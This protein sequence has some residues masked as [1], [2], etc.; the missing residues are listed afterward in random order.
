MPADFGGDRIREISGVDLKPVPARPRGQGSLGL[1]SE[2]PLTDRFQKKTELSVSRT[3]VEGQ[4]ARIQVP[5]EKVAGIEG[6]GDRRDQPLEAPDEGFRRETRL[7][8]AAAFPRGL[9]SLVKLF[10]VSQGFRLA[11][12]GTGVITAAFAA[13]IDVPPPVAAHGLSRFDQD[14]SFV[15]AE[16]TG[17]QGS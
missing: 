10:Q 8:V 11:Q 16:W 1:Q 14:R 7:R 15:I 6:P 12:S 3:Q 4:A 17:S 13:T 5:T 9:D 2:G